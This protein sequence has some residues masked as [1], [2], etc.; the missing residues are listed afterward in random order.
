MRFMMLYRPGEEVTVPNMDLMAEVGKLIEDWSKAGVLLAT[1]GLQHSAE[2][3]RVRAAGEE[4]TVTEGPFPDAAST[5]SGYAI[6]RVNSKAEAIDLAKRFLGVMGMGES[7]V[8]QLHDA[9][10]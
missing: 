5:I 9:P 3:A 7:E 1:E 6:V 2:G 4:F 10:Q 8:R